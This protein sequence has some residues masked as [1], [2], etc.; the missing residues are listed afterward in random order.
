MHRRFQGKRGL[1]VMFAD[2]GISG[3]MAN[4]FDTDVAPVTEVLCVN[5]IGPYLAIEHP[6]PKIAERA[7]ETGRGGAIGG[8]RKRI[9]REAQHRAARAR[10]RRL[11][12]RPRRALAVDGACPRATQ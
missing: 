9:A 7:K 3:G 5:L 2:A 12:R 6:A 10:A 8:R 4:I 11:I 1:D